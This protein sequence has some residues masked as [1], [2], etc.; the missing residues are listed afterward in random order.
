[1]ARRKPDGTVVDADRRTARSTWMTGRKWVRW[2]AR[3]K[4]EFLDALAASCNVKES[5]AAIGVEPAS[6]YHLRRRDEAFAASWAVA[7]RQGYDMLE[8]QLV[9][10]ALAGGGSG[11]GALLD[12]GDPARPPIDVDLALKLLREHRDRASG[13]RDPGG[14]KPVIATREQ[15]NAA[16]MK[17]LAAIE[18]RLAREDARRGGMGQRLRPG[19]AGRED[20]AGR[21]IVERGATGDD[22]RAIRAV[23]GG[24]DGGDAL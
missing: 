18:K 24:A 1:M 9:G 13:K 22:R 15:T 20:R 12:N 14:P 16:I 8:I 6:V 2:T 17:K 7:L 23:R 10:H 19:G 4:G 5:A 11:L 21:G 3:L